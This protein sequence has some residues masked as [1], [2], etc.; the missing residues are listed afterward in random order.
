MKR[1]LHLFSHRG[2]YFSGVVEHC[3]NAP[4]PESAPSPSTHTRLSFVCAPS[5]EGLR[6]DSTDAHS[7]VRCGASTLGPAKHCLKECS[8]AR[9]ALRRCSE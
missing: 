3:G 6:T 4:P 9:D 2:K 8:P 1:K 7:N 5:S